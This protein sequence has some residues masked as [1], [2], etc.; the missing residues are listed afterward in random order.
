MNYLDKE[1]LKHLW[2]KTK[3]YVE[4]NSGTGGSGGPTYFTK[5]I[6]TRYMS[7]QNPSYVTTDS[8]IEL[9]V[10][11]E[12]F[13]LY[14]DDVNIG[15]FTVKEMSSTELGIL[16]QIASQLDL[17][18]IPSKCTYI[19][20][21]SNWTNL[22]MAGE[23]GFVIA[24]VADVNMGN[25]YVYYNSASTKTNITYTVKETFRTP[26]NSDFFEPKL[27]WEGQ[28]TGGMPRF[29]ISDYY[30]KFSSFVIMARYDFG[31]VTHLPVYCARVDHTLAGS[32]RTSG[33]NEM[34][35][36]GVFDTEK[37]FKPLS[38]GG[39]Q[40]NT[41]FIIEKIYGIY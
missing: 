30:E 16:V 17:P 8:G 12:T 7:F 15:A 23:S 27:L 19:T 13:D 26:I 10:A 32:V 39:T 35:F 33:A 21:A 14:E 20:S 41:N 29:I 31:V 24:T 18:L 9:F 36:I 1:G 11:N 37:C 34:Y 3:E 40:M 2:Q 22:F 25:I 4:E 28:V 5:Q 38:A 6:S